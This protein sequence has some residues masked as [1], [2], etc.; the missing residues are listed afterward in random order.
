MVQRPRV[1]KD[2]GEFDL[3]FRKVSF[4]LKMSWNVQQNENPIISVLSNVIFPS[5]TV[6]L[7]KKH[8]WKINTCTLN[9]SKGHLQKFKSSKLV[10]NDASSKWLYSNPFSFLFARTDADIHRQTST[11]STFSS[12]TGVLVKR[13]YFHP[14]NPPKGQSFTRGR[15]DRRLV[16][17]IRLQLI[18]RSLSFMSVLKNIRLCNRM[19]CSEVVSATMTKTGENGTPL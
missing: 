18:R 5:L 2:Q 1:S 9:E 19:G 14:L 4:C 3:M 13:C 7:F 11:W 12:M 15:T 16:L 17:R 6:A 8:I 10:W